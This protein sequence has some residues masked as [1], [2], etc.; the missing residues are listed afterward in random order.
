MS[1]VSDSYWSSDYHD[2]TESR[3]LHLETRFVSTW[4]RPC[5]PM[6]KQHVEDGPGKKLPI[7]GRPVGLV[8]RPGFCP[9]SCL[10][11]PHV[12][13]GWVGSFLMRF[14]TFGGSV[15]PCERAWFIKKVPPWIDDVFRL[16]GCVSCGAIKCLWLSRN[17]C[18]GS[19][20][21]VFQ[22]SIYGIRQ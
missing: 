22:T 3:A 6:K 11:G 19:Y 16:M 4:N 15:D 14:A 17:S 7:V 18:L 21:L 8:V 9:R 10:E 1:S 2:D 13:Y 20:L 5:H 12:G